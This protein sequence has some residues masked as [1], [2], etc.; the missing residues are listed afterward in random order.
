[1]MYKTFKQ[2]VSMIDS[3]VYVYTAPVCCYIVA[4]MEQ[5]MVTTQKIAMTHQE[6][7]LTLRTI[8]ISTKGAQM[9][10]LDQLQYS[11]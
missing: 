9:I 10:S 3:M 4:R 11:I 7:M 8:Q 5:S 2:A 6:T 1:M